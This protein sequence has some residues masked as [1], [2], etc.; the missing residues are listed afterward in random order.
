[1]DGG[2]QLL[3]ALLP[4][5]GEGI[6]AYVPD[7]RRPNPLL[8]SVRARRRGSVPR[9]SRCHGNVA[10]GD[11][12]MLDGSG[13]VLVKLEGVRLRKVPRDWLARKVAGPLPDW[14]YELIWT[15]KP[16]EPRPQTDDHGSTTGWCLIRGMASA[17]S[18]LPDW[19]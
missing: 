14:C 16:L 3:G 8:L 9:S 2:F 18:S 6:D 13:R 4:G 11:I 1:M 17:A 12:Q 5:A 19:K 15:P 10:T 7:G